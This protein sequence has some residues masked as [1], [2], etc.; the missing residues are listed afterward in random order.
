MLGLPCQEATVRGNRQS[1]YR[2]GQIGDLLCLLDW[3]GA[4]PEANGPVVT[5]GD[6]R[7]AIRGENDRMPSKVRLVLQGLKVRGPFSDH[8]FCAHVPKPSHAILADRCE[9][10][11]IRRNSE[12]GQPGVMPPQ[13][14]QLLG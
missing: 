11:V 8:F 7:R 14:L 13:N 6:E 5:R 3:L 12:F 9:V 10:S 2:D 1:I 4:G